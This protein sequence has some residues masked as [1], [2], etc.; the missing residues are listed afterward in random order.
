MNSTI[1]DNILC[2]S[3]KKRLIKKAMQILREYIWS[4][5]DVKTIWDTYISYLISYNPNL[6]REYQ[7]HTHN[8]QQTKIGKC[9]T[10]DATIYV[11]IYVE[12]AC[13]VDSKPGWC[14]L[15]HACSSPVRAAKSTAQAYTP[16][17]IFIYTHP[18]ISQLLQLILCW[19]VSTNWVKI[20]WWVPSL[21]DASY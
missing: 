11:M 2:K 12:S 17:A 1:V 8:I 14:L 10:I 9:I 6:Q 5:L 13:S 4:Y 7:L 18:E 21:T 15:S 3:D 16:G 19:N 20:I